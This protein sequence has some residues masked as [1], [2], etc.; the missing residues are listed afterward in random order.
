[1]VRFLKAVNQIK[2]VTPRYVETWDPDSVLNLFLSWAPAKK[3]SLEIL[4]MKT[5]VL[6]LLVSG[7]RPQIIRNLDIGN[8]KVTDNHY[9]FYLN[10]SDLKE[11]RLNYKPE[12]LRFHKYPANK[13]LCIFNYLTEYLSRT[14]GIR[15][16]EKSLFI[17]LTAP[18]GRPSQ[19]TVSRWIKTV[20]KEAGI[21]T[22]LFSAGS[23]RSASTSK[24]ER[25][26]GPNRGHYESC[27]LG[28]IFDFHHLL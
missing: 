19:C 18:H 21:D 24:A 15:K 1:M 16:E 28:E 6:L 26:G 9:T 12:P 23:T 3:L 14:N 5:V 11:G 2:P 4:T 20:L 22:A 27:W 7:K 8:M 17:T 10:Q 13:K 25:G